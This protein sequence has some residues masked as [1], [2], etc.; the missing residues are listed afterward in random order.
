VT[1]LRRNVLALGADYALF[2]VGLAF[3]S[4]ATILPAF[5]ASLGAPNVVIGAIPAVMTLGWALPSLFAAGH[6]AALPRK[7]PFVVRWT[8]L[9]RLPFPGLAL[10]AFLVADRAPA[11]TLAL[12]LALLLA[13]TG[14]GG[15]LMPAWMDIVGRA[16]PTRMRGRF[17]ALASLAAGML[18]FGAS[19]LAARALTAWPGAPGFGI[20]FLGATV[21]MALSFLALLFVREPPGGTAAPAIPLGDHL[22]RVPSLLRRDPNLAWYLVARGLAVVGTMA[23]GFFTVHALRAWEAPAGQ[24]GLFTA[25]LLA[26][27]V[28]G[29]A[30]LGWVADRTGHRV[31]I[32]AGIAATLAANGVALAAPSLALFGLVFVLTGFQNAA[33]T[34]SNLNVLLEF[35]P[36]E[37]ERPTYIGLGLTAMAPVSFGAPLAAGLLA[38]LTGL[39][40]VFAL[41]ALAALVGLG[42]LWARVRDPRATR[43]LA[44]V[45][46]VGA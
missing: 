26:G 41:A 6:T 23:A 14:V 20:C 45:A 39:R 15:A 2:M 37:K 38:D 7:L 18:G 34:V 36:S 1:D 8:V 32:M 11:L 24:V 44:P 29:T 33:I 22:R 4:Q 5:A 40:A 28:L 13:I 30:T 42:L 25:L 43:G 31:V 16:I 9:E 3:A 35:A 46:E 19:L 12:M 10:L 17:F 27:Q 21:A